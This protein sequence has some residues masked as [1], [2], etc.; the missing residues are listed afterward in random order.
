VTDHPLRD[1]RVRFL[2]ALGIAVVIVDGDRLVP[3][4]PDAQAQVE[5]L[6]DAAG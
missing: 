6:L 4:S 3:G 5:G 1:K 2:S